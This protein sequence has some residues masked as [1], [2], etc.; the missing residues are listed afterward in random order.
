MEFSFAI[1][2]RTGNESDWAESM[3]YGCL[4]CALEASVSFQGIA[5]GSV[6]FINSP[7]YTEIELT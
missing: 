5:L 6:S 7:S 4:P 2:E 3:V 1:G